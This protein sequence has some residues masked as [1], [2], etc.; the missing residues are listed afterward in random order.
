MYVL[1]GARCLLGSVFLMSFL[2][3]VCGRARY[4]GFAAAARRLTPRALGGRP[5]VR[6]MVAPAVVTAE[7]AACVLLAV[8]ATVLP[9]MAVSC[10]LLTVF[11][12]AT[13]AALRHGDRAP[14]HCFGSSR[15]RLGTGHVLR[16]GLMAALA[17]AG[18]VAAADRARPLAAA[19][20]AVVVAVALAAAV[21]V[22]IADDIADVFRSAG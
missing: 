7:A 2:G 14:C 11:A 3:K 15:R 21:L 12:M 17:L 8:P 18:I 22:V 4:A 19:Q 13:S 10:V 9:G 20:A 16:N 1:L 6:R 5:L